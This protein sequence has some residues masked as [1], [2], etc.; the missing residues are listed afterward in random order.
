MFPSK[1]CAIGDSFVENL[2]N[3]DF[4]QLFNTC[5]V[6][7][8]CFGYCMPYWLLSATCFSL[9]TLVP[10]FAWTERNCSY[11]GHDKRVHFFFLSICSLSFPLFSFKILSSFWSNL[12]SFYINTTTSSQII[13]LKIFGCWIFVLGELLA[14]KLSSQLWIFIGQN[15]YIRVLSAQ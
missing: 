1:I 15:L 14:R 10:M 7:A 9:T 2:G 12:F 8:T 11:R 3:L 5:L 4:F 13:R 6:M